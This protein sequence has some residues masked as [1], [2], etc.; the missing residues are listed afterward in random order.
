MMDNKKNNSSNKSNT[1]NNWFHKKGGYRWIMLIIAIITLLSGWFGRGIIEEWDIEN[2]IVTFDQS[3]GN[4]T[5]INNLDIPDPKINSQLIEINT[6]ID[7]L[8]LSKIEVNIDSKVPLMN[9]Y[10]QVEVP[11]LVSL[12][13]YPK[14]SVQMTASNNSGKNWAYY[15]IY[16]PL[17]NVYIGEIKTTEQIK[18]KEDISLT[19]IPN[20]PT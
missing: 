14:T 4:N 16:N 9:L 18:N 5:I 20:L 10:I 8:F 11:E 6:P 7:D 3:G 15:F 2:S 13:I 17:D 12:K 1:F 19:V